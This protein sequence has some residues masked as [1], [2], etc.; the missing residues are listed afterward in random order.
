MANESNIQYSNID[1]TFPVAGKDN[2]SQ[3]FRD[4][5]SA[6]KN[7]LQAAYTE[8]TDLRVHAARLDGGEGGVNDFN[9][10]NIKKV[11]L[12]EYSESAPTPQP[13]NAALNTNI[14][15]YVSD[16]SYQR[17]Q[18]EGGNLHFTITGFPPTNKLGKIRLHITGDGTPR[19]LTFSAA[20]SVAIKKSNNVPTSIIVTS[21]I[22]PIMLDLWSVDGGNQIYMDYVGTFT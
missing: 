1:A 22:N 21:N 15:V 9:W 7:S 13:I 20:G 8:V 17:F 14:T 11:N 3:G 10:T 16:G 2:N 12:I 19:T 4:N 18:V 5:F 6:I